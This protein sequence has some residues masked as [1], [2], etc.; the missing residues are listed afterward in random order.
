M[1]FIFST[2]D[3]S[4]TFWTWGRDVEEKGE[5]DLELWEDKRE[6][7]GEDVRKKTTTEMR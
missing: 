7:N 4:N 5:Q 6:G 1:R 3:D 2:L